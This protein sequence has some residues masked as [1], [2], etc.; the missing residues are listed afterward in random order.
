MDDETKSLN[1]P[2]EEIKDFN[3]Q[4]GSYRQSDVASQ[5]QPQI[6]TTTATEKAS[7]PRKPIKK[8]YIVAVAFM[9]LIVTFALGLMIGATIQNNTTHKSERTFDE[10]LIAPEKPMI[11]LYPEAET[12]VSVQLGRPELLTI[13][14]PAYENGWK[15]LAK[16]DGTL[17]DLRNEDSDNVDPGR[18]FYGLYWEGIGNDTT[19][20]DN[21]FVVTGEDTAKF[22]EEKLA[23]LGLTDREANEFIIYWLPQLE[24][25]AY[26]Y[27]R[28][29]S[30][31]EI[32]E[33]MPLEITPEPDSVIRIIMTYRPLDEPIE[34][35]EQVLTTPERKGFTV[36]EWG[37]TEIGSEL[38]R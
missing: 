24:K 37:G 5:E 15:V 20:E 36:V 28:F 26:N 35:K 27:I 13:T 33:Y 3:S 29:E 30:R 22:L 31:E 32:D 17:R 34:M 23:I 11:Y 12:E 7:K 9:A 14:Y 25:N 10:G 16:P 8:S 6:I 18:D 21:G 2:N 38:V 19:V 4:T 1:M